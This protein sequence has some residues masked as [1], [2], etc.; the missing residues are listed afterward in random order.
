MAHRRSTYEQIWER[1]LTESFKTSDVV[2]AFLKRRGRTVDLTKAGDLVAA[3]SFDVWIDG[4]DEALP[5]GL[6]LA[7]GLSQI[8]ARL[9]HQLANG[10]DHVSDG[11]FAKPPQVPQRDSRG[12]RV[13]WDD[14]PLATWDRVVMVSSDG[15]M[16]GLVSRPVRR[17]TR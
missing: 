8:E 11:G 4:N 16:L 3:G 1:T 14:S 10:A 2:A 6:G 13:P 5:D 9:L 7:S 15:P 12:S 17:G